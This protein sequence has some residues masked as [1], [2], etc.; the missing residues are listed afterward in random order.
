MVEIYNWF[1]AHWVE[2]VNVITGLIAVAS[3]IVR[4]TPTLKDDTA[5]LAI[6]K[7]IA[8]FIALDRGVD[9]DKVR[10]EPK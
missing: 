2:I 1:V 5:L 7:F 10:N 3:V 8:N 6:I 9:D 4:W